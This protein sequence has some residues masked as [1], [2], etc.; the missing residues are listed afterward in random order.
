MHTT[1]HSDSH[2]FSPE[3]ADLPVESA[4]L[5]AEPVSQSVSQI[6]EL[7]LKSQLLRR[8]FPVEPARNQHRQH[9]EFESLLSNMMICLFLLTEQ[10]DR[11]GI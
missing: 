5:I 1:C 11:C 2:V 9:H 10:L 6:V 8:Q 7:L 3:D 4:P